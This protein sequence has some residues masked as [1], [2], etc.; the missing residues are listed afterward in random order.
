MTKPIRGKVARVLNT[1]E[2]A[3][4]V[5]VE[6]GVTV[7]MY[8]DVMDLQYEDIRD[9]DTDEV[10]G[11]IERP[12]VRVKVIHV[13]EKLSLTTTY[14]SKRVNT[15]GSLMFL[16]PFAR[17]LMPP[18]W[19]TRYE[20]L[21]KIEENRNV[22]DEEDSNVKIGDSI[23]QVIEEINTEGELLREDTEALNPATED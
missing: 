16:G 22:L 11:S 6:D 8:F 15:G 3:I 23:A 21:S 9:P 2:I 17:S 4:N 7:G 19:V 18:N 1:R 14:R 20:T 13:Q 12:K 10:L 5:G